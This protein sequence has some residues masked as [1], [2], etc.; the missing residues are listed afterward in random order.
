MLT[1]HKSQ[2]TGKGIVKLY[3][4]PMNASMEAMLASP[5]VGR[6]SH[7]PL[8]PHAIHCPIMLTIINVHMV[9]SML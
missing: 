6:K 7:L 5:K 4:K 3:V 9:A 2:R 1:T 8:R